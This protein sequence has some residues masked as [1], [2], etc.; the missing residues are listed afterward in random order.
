MGKTIAITGASGLTGSFVL[1]E[2]CRD[3]QID[4]ILY[5]ARSSP[6]KKDQKIEFIDI[7]RMEGHPKLATAE[8]GVCCLGTTIK[9]AGSKENFEDVDYRM[10]VD[11][12]RA[13]KDAKQ[14]M[15]ISAMGADANSSVFYNRVKGKMEEKLKELHFS[16]LRIFRPSI[17]S[18]PRDEFRLGERIGL[19]L[20]HF[21]SPILLGTLKHYRPIKAK[22][23]AHAIY[24]SIYE[25]C[26]GVET[27]KS[28][29]IKKRAG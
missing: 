22:T 21:I 4:T 7:H 25:P 1:D 9:K 15:V 27:I 8:L 28:D 23:L 19:A 29:D 11:F 20:M 26:T 17:L 5:V 13:C 3:G 12:A 18:G 6:E 16:C 24:K 14:F 2:L 10:V